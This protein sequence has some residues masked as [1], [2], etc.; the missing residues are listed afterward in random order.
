MK[1]LMLRTL[2]LVTA[3]GYL[4]AA[5]HTHDHGPGHSHCIADTTAQH[6]HAGDSAEEAH[7][8]PIC[9]VQSLT[10]A[11]PPPYDS[12]ALFAPEC[13]ETFEATFASEPFFFPIS[14]TARAPPFA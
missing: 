10:A 3:L 1:K 4:L 6:Q 5:V 13:Y 14:I 8:C 12:S 9:T 2:L 7:D 11:V